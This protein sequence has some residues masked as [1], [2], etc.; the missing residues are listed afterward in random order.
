MKFSGI[1]T[2]DRSEDHAKDQGQR[3]EVKITE[4]KT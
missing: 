2:S 1:I 4:V 3:S